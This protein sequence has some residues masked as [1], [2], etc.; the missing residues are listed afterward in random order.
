MNNVIKIIISLLAALAV[1]LAG[2]FANAWKTRNEVKKEVK[3]A[4]GDLNKEQAKALK[5]LKESYEEKLKKKDEIIK[6]LHT[7]IDRLLNVLQTQ[8]PDNKAAANK[9]V[10]SLIEKLE[11]QKKNLKNL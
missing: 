9:A 1:F 11:L 6:S 5:A 4:I 3:K 2:W 7:I 10:I 8:Q